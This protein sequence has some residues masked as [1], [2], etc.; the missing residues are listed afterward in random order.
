L[1]LALLPIPA[2]AQ[3]T[4][5]IRVAVEGA[6]PPFN[7]F[8]SDGA[9][10][11]FE[12]D[13]LN[14]LCA[15]MRARCTLQPREWD[16]IV[17]GLI[18]RD[19][20][21][22][23]SSLEITAKREKRIAFSRPYYRIPASFIGRKD[24]EAPA[25]TREGLAGKTVGTIHDSEHVDYL[26]KHFPDAEVRTYGKLEEAD[27]DLLTERVDLVLGDKLSLSKFLNSRE[28][29]CCRLVGD[30][31]YDPAFHG[32]GYGIGLRKEDQDLKAAFD[33]AIG[34]VI[35]DGTYDRIRSKYFAFDIR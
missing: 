23:M 28:G 5:S 21:A 2:A 14:A 27:L 17:R 3:E 6:Y 18:N 11:G 32:R 20:D 10:Q 26:K 12:V 22:I 29:A 31:P 15:A 35:A 4:P 24:A 13:L 8:G 30:A 19:Y 16:G 1:L 7:F 33:R 34:E 25:L 9:L